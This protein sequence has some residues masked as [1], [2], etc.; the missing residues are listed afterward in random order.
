MRL[1]LATSLNRDGL[2][3][4]KHAG[5]YIYNVTKRVMAFS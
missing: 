4:R 2:N 5:D 3:V 1:Q